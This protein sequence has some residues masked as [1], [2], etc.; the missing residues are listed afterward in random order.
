M[1]TAEAATRLGVSQRQV[2]RL[3][4]SGALTGT[5]RVGRAWLLDASSV[6]R[7]GHGR[8]GDGYAT[9]PEADAV[10]RVCHLLADPVGNVMLRVTDQP[11]V[12]AWAGP[13]PMAVVGIDLM[14]S[15]D[16]REAAVGRHLLEGL[17]P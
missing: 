4:A 7:P 16:P 14:E 13:M 10:V 17:L 15:T 3:I 8:R 6:V 11:V 9:G 12:A 1:T 5:R 2:Q